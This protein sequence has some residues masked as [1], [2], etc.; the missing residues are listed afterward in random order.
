MNEILQIFI[1]IQNLDSE[2][3]ELKHKKASLPQEIQQLENEIRKLTAEKENVIAS[4]KKEEVKLRE[5]EV[6]LRE[7][8]EKIRNFQEK[9]RQVKSNEEY[10]AMISQIEHAN[11]EKVK[12]EEEI[13]LQM[14]LVERLQKELPERTKFLEEK[15]KELE[16]A[17]NISKQQLAEIEGRLAINEEKKKVLLEKLPEKEKQ[18]YLKLQS[19]YGSYAICRVIENELPKAEKD[20]VCSG[21]YSV[22][23]LSFVQEL[24]SKLMYS[25]CPNCGRIIYYHEEV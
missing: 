17:V 7:I 2:I 18:L 4:F 21:C 13:V 16:N 22:L 11:M 8:Q 10:R 25:R 23:P 20:Y 15:K 12:K 1:Q 5:L 14:E 6:D 24:K 9:S 19:R 3:E